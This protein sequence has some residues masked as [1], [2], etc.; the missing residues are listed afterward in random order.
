MRGKYTGFT[1]YNSIYPVNINYSKHLQYRKD[2]E[3]NSDTKKSHEFSATSQNNTFPNGAKV[4]IDYSKGQINISQVLTDFRSTILA[5]NAPD[6]VKEEV[7]V[8]LNLVEKESQKENPSREII[9]G[10]LKNA[11]KVSDAY[12]ASALK[13][14]SDVVEK[15]I[16]TLFLQRINL[17]ADPS[18]I[19]PDFLLEFPKHA[20]EKIDAQKNTENT[21]VEN[22]ISETIND[23]Q[24]NAVHEV[25]NEFDISPKNDEK[26]SVAQEAQITIANES[27][28]AKENIE[29]TS[30]L[31]L[32]QAPK[33]QKPVYKK[34]NE[35]IKTLFS[36]L[37]DADAKAKKLFTQAK[38]LP[39]TN[40][41][42]SK[43][44]NLLNEALGIMAKDENVNQ[45]IRAAIHI[46]RG[47]IFDNYDYV[48]YALRDYFEAT[49]AQDYNLKSQAHF[50]SGQ[51]YDEFSEFYPALDN[52][53]SSVAYCA[54]AENSDAQA[55]VLTKI[56]DLYTKQYDIKNALDYGSLAID[57]ANETE[58]KELIARTYSADAQNSQYLGDNNRALDSYKNALSVFSKT[59]ESY[60]TMAY[61]YE[62][63]AIV[64]RKL[65]NH[66][67]AAKLQS[68]ANQ[69]YQKSLQS[70]VQQEEAS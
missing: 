52:Y 27:L 20:Q 60:E 21:F 48:D 66:A 35:N 16:D 4:A 29:T 9:L 34:T 37:C 26:I 49:K 51:I 55:R 50:K 11:S 13:K 59:N 15:W 40:E 69:Y 10:N 22:N 23:A 8:Y 46:E 57:T 61:N 28:D 38:K 45:N 5:I 33:N 43:A 62:Q 30:E 24:T 7:S 42:D 39:Q 3:E 63:A 70:L 56:A 17:K 6:N 32:S 68:K 64:M 65:G 47:K 44:L 2:N 1:L 58:N 14:P 31:E 41:G 36:P 54:E 12:I 25:Q 19:N 53:L 67:K 18:E